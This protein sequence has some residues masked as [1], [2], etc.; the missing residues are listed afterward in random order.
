MSGSSALLGAA[1]DYALQTVAGIT[2]EA[3]ESTTPCAGW[4][5]GTLLAH[6]NDSLAAL[7]EGIDGGR[8]GLFPA[9]SPA[10]DSDVV[11]TFHRR[12]WLLALACRLRPADA[13]IGG[14]PI[15]ADVLTGI[16]AIE[17]AVHGWDVAQ[18]RHRARPIPAGLAG[19]LLQFCPVLGS[20]A[21]RHRLFAPPRAVSA[22]AGPGDRLV[23]FLGRNP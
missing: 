9:D 6:V 12:A 8:I 13:T 15:S 2:P 5:L 3:L 17:I 14:C 21:T 22:Q 18:A 16:G 11:D 23:A 20:A 10:F 7:Y 19:E 4:D 1:V